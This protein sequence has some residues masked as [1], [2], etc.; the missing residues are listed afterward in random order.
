[1]F[2]TETNSL[3]KPSDGA[4]GLGGVSG[5]SMRIIYL[6]RKVNG[7]INGSVCTNEAPI[8]ENIK[9]PTAVKDDSKVKL[10]VRTVVERAF[11]VCFN[12]YGRVLI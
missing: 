2:N 6:C 9:V 1:M 10:K 7:L 4:K 8:L 5:V 12:L 11:Y 3:K